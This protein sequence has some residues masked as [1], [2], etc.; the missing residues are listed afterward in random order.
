MEEEGDRPEEGAE[1]EAMEED[2][3]PEAGAGGKAVA[4]QE[5]EDEACGNEA[6]EEGG[7]EEEGRGGEGED[8]RG[9][10]GEEGVDIRRGEGEGEGDGEGVGDQN[11]DGN[12][13]AKLLDSDDEGAEGGA[14][15]RKGGEESDNLREVIVLMLIGAWICWLVLV[16]ANL[17]SV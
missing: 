7:Q 9:E 12:A 14:E 11:A 10:E 15:T 3:E 17:N 1:G 5:V 13:V 8:D 16:L 6:E 4:E 2:Q